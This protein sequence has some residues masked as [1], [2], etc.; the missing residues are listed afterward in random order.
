MTLTET[1]RQTGRAPGNGTVLIVDDDAD[2]RDVLR[3]FLEFEG[4]SVV[5][6]ADGRAALAALERTRN[7]CS[8]LLDLMMPVMDGWEFL[9][10]R[11]ADA[12]LS[13]IPVI[14]I[15]AFRDRAPTEGVAGVVS[16]PIDF[17][18]LLNVIRRH[19]R[20]LPS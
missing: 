11:R 10:A 18:E 14:I 12:R 9:E 4:Y 8:I 17:T 13:R 6:T 16:K 19:C 5:T 3:E 2:T 15:S 1:T 7:T 20:S